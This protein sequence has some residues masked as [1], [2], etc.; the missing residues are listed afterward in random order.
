MIWLYYA[1]L[2]LILVAGLALAL[3]SLPGLW[4]ML[5]ALG[6]YA[7]ITG[8]VYIGWKGLLIL[9]ILGIAA[10]A[11]E[12]LLG[13]MAAKRAGGSRRAALGALIGGTLGAIFLTFGLFLIGTVIGACLGSAIGAVAGELTVRHDPAPLGRLARVGWAAAH[14]RLIALVVKLLFG[15]II[16]LAGLLM[17]LPV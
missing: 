12:A 7:W 11:S 13:G 10:E 15:V 6:L 16:L 3:L 17:A 14:G 4:V 9:L 8:G 5:G 1:L 2:A